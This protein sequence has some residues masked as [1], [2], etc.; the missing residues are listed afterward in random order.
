VNNKEP[1]RETDVENLSDQLEIPGD[2]QIKQEGKSINSNV[3]D[4]EAT[5]QEDGIKSA[6]SKDKNRQLKQQTWEE[7]AQSYEQVPPSNVKA[8]GPDGII[9]DGIDIRTY[10]AVQ[11]LEEITQARVVF[12]KKEV[13]VKVAE[14]QL[15]QLKR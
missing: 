15:I 8:W 6:T 5:V 7:R 9:N 12:E 10:A 13:L 3:I 4:V 14:D 11:A 2:E 1:E